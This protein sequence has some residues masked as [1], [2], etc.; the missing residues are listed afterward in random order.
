MK[1]E[2]RLPLDEIEVNEG[3]ALLVL[4]GNTIANSSV[5]QSGCGCGCGCGAGQ[6]CGCGCYLGAG[7][8]CNAGTG[9]GCSCA[10]PTINTED[11]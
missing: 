6:D 11:P 3:Q 9:C 10:L 1:K 7:C 4:G 5:T 8:D 2:V